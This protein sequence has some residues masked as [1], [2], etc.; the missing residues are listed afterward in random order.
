MLNT[1]RSVHEEHRKKDLRQ[2]AR[3]RAFLSQAPNR[4]PPVTPLGLINPFNLP[5]GPIIER[6]LLRR[7]PGPAEGQERHPLFFTPKY[8]PCLRTR[9]TNRALMPRCSFLKLGGISNHTTRTEYRLLLQHVGSEKGLNAKLP[10]FLLRDA[11]KECGLES[12]TEARVPPNEILT[13]ED[14]SGKRKIHAEL[15]KISTRSRR[16][17]APGTR[18]PIWAPG[19]KARF[20]S[21]KAAPRR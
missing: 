20:S 4:S 13:P 21:S 17:C 15:E 11:C 2:P 8:R 5:T 18:P 10:L 9:K 14:E 16:T 7:P 6:L 12:G 1:K 19:G 3:L